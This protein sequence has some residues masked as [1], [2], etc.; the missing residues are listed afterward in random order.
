MP[1]KA[2]CPL[3]QRMPF[4]IER[5]SGT[6][7]MTALCRAFGISR[8]TG[9][10]WAKRFELAD[11]SCSLQELSRRPQNDPAVAA[12]RIVKRILACRHR[13]PTWGP[14]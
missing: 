2:A 9:Y 14:R 13:H 1:W 7:S 3:E 6:M 11:S 8:Q 4:V 10:K 5:R 12:T